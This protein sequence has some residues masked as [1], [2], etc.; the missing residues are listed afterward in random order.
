[1]PTGTLD[2]AD[3]VKQLLAAP[4]LHKDNGP[5]IWGGVFQAAALEAFLA[6]WPLTQ[7]P[8]HIWEYTHRMTFVRDA[9]PEPPDI[10]RL[11]R[12]RIFGEG[13]DLSLRRDGGC[14]LWHFVGQRNTTK[15]AGF[16]VSDFWVDSPDCKENPN[17]T[18]RANNEHALLWGDY[19]TALGRWQDDRVGWADLNYPLSAAKH[20]GQR[21]EIHY[22]VYT[23]GGQ[24]AFVW[25]KELKAYA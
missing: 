22:T 14:F 7:M 20:Q 23:D 16:A 2:F 1:M 4:L 3:A 5:V 8:Y 25:W 9:P 24:V 12:G 6:A 13:G 17:F 21:A 15:P 11:E 10:A 19:K 18:L